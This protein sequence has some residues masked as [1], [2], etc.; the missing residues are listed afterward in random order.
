[1]L[2]IQPISFSNLQCFYPL[3]IY[4]T[5]LI[6]SGLILSESLLNSVL[7]INMS[8]NEFFLYSKNKHPGSN[9]WRLLEYLM[10]VKDHPHEVCA[11]WLELSNRWTFVSNIIHIYILEN[12]LN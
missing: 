4:L 7:G 10:V 12:Y 5:A 1:L 11:L 8:W 9:P 2:N 3:N 6:F